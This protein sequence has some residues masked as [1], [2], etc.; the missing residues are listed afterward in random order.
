MVDRHRAQDPSSG[1]E[2]EARGWTKWPETITKDQRQLKKAGEKVHEGERG[3]VEIRWGL[4]VGVE[5]P[6]REDE[7]ISEDCG[8]CDEKGVEGGEE[9]VGGHLREFGSSFLKEKQSGLRRIS[10]F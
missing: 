6:R 4:D 2:C 9:G 8:E 7:T 10:N 5:D 3:Q 1:D